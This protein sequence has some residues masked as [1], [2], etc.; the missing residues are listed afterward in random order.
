MTTGGVEDTSLHFKREISAVVKKTTSL[1]CQKRSRT[2]VTFLRLSPL[3]VGPASANRN[4]IPGSPFR[5]RAPAAL[6]FWRIRHAKHDCIDQASID[7]I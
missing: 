7:P 6:T 3:D 2:C 5:G 1:A 4:D